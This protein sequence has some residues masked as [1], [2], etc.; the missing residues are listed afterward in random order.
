MNSLAVP[1]ALYLCSSS[2]VLKKNIVPLMLPTTNVSKILLNQCPMKSLKTWWE[3]YD[4]S[5]LG[6]RAQQIHITGN[7]QLTVPVLINMQEASLMRAER[8]THLQV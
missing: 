4:I 5:I 3:S 8:C 6:L 1:V 2:V 7:D